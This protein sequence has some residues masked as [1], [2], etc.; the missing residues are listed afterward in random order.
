MGFGGHA[1]TELQC[2]LMEIMHK[3]MSSSKIQEMITC[4]L[5]SGIACCLYNFILYQARKQ[6][7]DSEVG[8]VNTLFM[9]VIPQFCANELTSAMDTW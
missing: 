4:S 3:W 1:Y 8:R 9:H 2:A 6:L 7:T 5:E